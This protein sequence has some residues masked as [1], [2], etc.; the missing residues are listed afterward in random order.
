M[1]EPR[2][3][4][5]LGR[6]AKRARARVCE[7]WHFGHVLAIRFTGTRTPTPPNKP[8]TMYIRKQFAASL[9]MYARHEPELRSLAPA[10]PQS[11]GHRSHAGAKLCSTHSSEDVITWPGGWLVV[12]ID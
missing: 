5:P 3:V 8:P 1:A 9:E 2:K 7:L 4:R 10:F 11:H 12:V 6:N